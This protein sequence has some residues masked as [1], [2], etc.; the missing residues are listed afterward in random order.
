MGPNDPVYVIYG[1]DMDR[2]VRW[3][4]MA[5]AGD[6]YHDAM[7][8]AGCKYLA[9]DANQAVDKEWYD[10]FRAELQRGLFKPLGSQCYEVVP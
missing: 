2:P 1:A 10:P 8:K 6:S 9:I 3:L 4:R 7:V 5:K